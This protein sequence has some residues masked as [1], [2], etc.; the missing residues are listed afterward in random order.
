MAIGIVNIGIGSKGILRLSDVRGFGDGMGE[1]IQLSKIC[2]LYCFH[3]IEQTPTVKN[4]AVINAIT[5]IISPYCFPNT[6]R[7]IVP[8][9][10]LKIIKKKRRNTAKK[11]GVKH[12]NIAFAVLFS[13]WILFSHFFQGV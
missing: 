6:R 9:I 13:L 10:K 8:Y 11:R 2:F 4:N 12:Q 1:D 7:R 5:V 3:S